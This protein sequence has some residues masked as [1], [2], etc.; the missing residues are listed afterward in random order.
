MISKPTYKSVVKFALLI[1][2]CMASGSSN[3]QTN[4]APAG[5]ASKS[6]NFQNSYFATRAIDGNRNGALNNNSVASTAGSTTTDYWQVDLGSSNA[7]NAVNIYNRT[8]CC[9]NRLANVWVLL[10]NNPFPADLAD[11]KTSATYL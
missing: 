8:D 10:S 3:A 9:G 5:V 6:S 7:I 2:A 1:V 11:A 4:L